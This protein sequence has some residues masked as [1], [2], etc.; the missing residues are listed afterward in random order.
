MEH[1]AESTGSIGCKFILN[2]SV[3]CWLEK[4]PLRSVSVT[5]LNIDSTPEGMKPLLS[6]TDSKFDWPTL[7]KWCL[8]RNIF[9]NEKRYS[10]A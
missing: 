5:V 8:H 10:I 1:I 2:N 3:G 7:E 6:I 4:I 9:F